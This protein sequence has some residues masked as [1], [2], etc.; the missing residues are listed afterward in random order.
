MVTNKLWTVERL[1]LRRVTGAMP[2]RHCIATA[3]GSGYLTTMVDRKSQYLVLGRSETKQANVIR[4][5]IGRG[6]RC[7]GNLP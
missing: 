5:V 7:H 3:K 1:P 6:F 4:R 2:L